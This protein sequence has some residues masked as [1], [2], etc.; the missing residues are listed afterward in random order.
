MSFSES[1]ALVQFKRGTLNDIYRQ[2]QPHLPL[3]GI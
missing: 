3:T 1:Y 2:A